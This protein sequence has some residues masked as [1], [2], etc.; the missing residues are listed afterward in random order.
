MSVANN[1]LHL[2]VNKT[3]ENTYV[4]TSSLKI[5]QILNAMF[6]KISYSVCSN[7]F[8]NRNNYKFLKVETYSAFF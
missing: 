6:L 5:C 2:H 7:N 1:Q 3:K 8:I 4:H